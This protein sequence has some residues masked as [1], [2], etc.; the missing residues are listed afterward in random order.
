[1]QLN[2]LRNLFRSGNTG[3]SGSGTGAS[4]VSALQGSD[5]G[6]LL[7][8]LTMGDQLQ[9]G[10]GTDF[11]SLLSGNSQQI[12]Q[13]LARGLSQS[14]GNAQFQGNAA[15][16]GQALS[17]NVVALLQSLGLGGQTGTANSGASGGQTL[18]SIL[19]GNAPS[20]VN[21]L[22]GNQSSGSGGTS[23][24]R[25]AASQSATSGATASLDAES[26][27]GDFEDIMF[28]LMMKVVSQMQKEVLAEKSKM[29]KPRPREARKTTAPKAAA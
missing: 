7:Q 16:T 8:F 21:P 5:I 25:G 19:A 17:P 18:Q 12:S 24:L 22:S 2:D 9:S 29:P 6:Q 4:D 11:S 3:T 28:S 13:S 1:M 20:S 10:G 23:A 14:Q 15:Q 26:L 27:G